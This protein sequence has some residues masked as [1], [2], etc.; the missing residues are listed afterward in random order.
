MDKGQEKFF[1]FMLSRAQEGKE[2]ALKEFLAKSFEIVG[3]GQATAEFFEQ[4]NAEL[5]NLVKPEFVA[6]IIGITKNFQQGHSK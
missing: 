1:E 2:T 4:F 6:E 3:S 5:K